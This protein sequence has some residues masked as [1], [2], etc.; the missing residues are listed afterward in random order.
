MPTF[1]QV[2]S[3]G[4]TYHLHNSSKV[5]SVGGALTGASTTP[6]VIEDAWRLEAWRGEG[7]TVDEE[8]TVLCYGSN[9]DNVVSTVRTLRQILNTTTYTNAPYLLVQPDGATSAL[10]FNIERADVQEEKIQ[11]EDGYASPL[12]GETRI[13]LRIRL[14]RSAFGGRLTTPETLISAASSQNQSSGT[15]DNV[16][17]FGVGAGD[18]IN[19]GQPCNYTFTPTTTA[20]G[21]FIFRVTLASIASRTYFAVPS[22][23]VAMSTTS[24]VFVNG[25]SASSA[26]AFNLASM[27]YNRRLKLRLIA[28]LSVA[29]SA[30][31]EIRFRVVG[32]STLAQAR[33]VVYSPVLARTD[34]AGFIQRVL[35]SGPIPLNIDA[36]R[37]LNDAQFRTGLQIRSVDGLTATATVT[38]MEAILY[39]DWCEVRVGGSP[40]QWGDGAS[41]LWRLNISSFAER[42]GV[43]CLPLDRP[44]AFLSD[45]ATSDQIVELA[46]VRGTVPRY[47]PGAS[48]WLLALNTTSSTPGSGTIYRNTAQTYTITATHA[49]LYLTMRGAG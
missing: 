23:P 47:Y 14:R 40:L 2:I 25:T 48:L 32:G 22:S 42:S 41:A 44:T 34:D 5:P 38:H 18:L 11:E 45:S 20:G 39:Y 28:V 9:H 46:Q 36:W 3:G 17:A 19:A 33:D 10:H 31:A 37:S 15:P 7:R 1:V 8:F 4:V 24:T 30:N 26:T 6:L 21:D 16:D 49:P 13:R 29:P 12:E 27:V 43:P 35:D